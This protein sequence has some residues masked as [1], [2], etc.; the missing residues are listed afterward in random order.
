MHDMEWYS[1]DFKP[2][3][4][5]V[6]PDLKFIYATNKVISCVGAG[7]HEACVNDFRRLLLSVNTS[8]LAER[9]SLH[10]R[11][12]AFSVVFYSKE[13]LCSCVIQWYP[14]K[15]HVSHILWAVEKKDNQNNSHKKRHGSP[16]SLSS[17][18]LQ[19]C[20]MCFFGVLGVPPDI[21]S[22]A[23]VCLSSRCD[24]TVY[25]ISHT[26]MP[27]TSSPNYLGATEQCKQRAEIASQPQKNTNL[28]LQQG[29]VRSYSGLLS[30]SVKH[31]VIVS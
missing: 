19:H 16:G 11:H 28:Q 1:L 13:A 9:F 3:A 8:A 31:A 5:A 10:R 25:I 24:V 4:L 20:M 17:I 21:E 7:V 15:A 23:K 30:R 14:N 6:S 26:Q 22:P 12:F 2:S 27:K 18:I 29:S